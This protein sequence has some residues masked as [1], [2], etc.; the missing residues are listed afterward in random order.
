MPAQTTG[1][2][3]IVDDD[4][5]CRVLVKTILA[6]Q[7]Y[8]IDEASNGKEAIFRLHEAPPALII[9]DIMMPVMNGYDVAIHMKQRAETKSIPIIMLTAK[10]ESADILSGY[11][12]YAVDYY[13]TKPFT[14]KQLLLGIELV[15]STENENE[16]ITP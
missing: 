10:G 15:L 3:L 13:I 11:T 1:H 14:A 12:D 4:P 16:Q 8:R 6:S 5:D 9:L 7:G 2:I